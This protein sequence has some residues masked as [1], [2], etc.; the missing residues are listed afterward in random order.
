MTPMNVNLLHPDHDIDSRPG[1]VADLTADLELQ[2]LYSAM[3][4]GDDYLFEVAQRLV[5]VP[6]NDPE[7]ISYRQHVLADCLDDPATVQRMYTV[8][9]D[10]VNARRKVWLSGMMFQAPE[11]ILHRGVGLMTV[12]SANLR[13]IRDIADD[14]RTTFGSDGF[15]RLFAM[16]GEQLP[17]D[18]LAQIEH[19]VHELELHRGIAL[20]ARLGPGNKA[21]D[22]T[23]HRAPA[24]PNILH[25][26]TG[27]GHTGVDFDLPDRD[28][29]GAQALT[30][31][32]GHGIAD[33]AEVLS[34]A[35]DDIQAFFGRLRFELAFYLGCVNL[36][37]KLTELGVP[38]CF[39]NPS[40]PDQQELWCRGLRDVGLC[41]T[42]VAAVTGNDIDADG[43]SL[44]MITGANEGGKSTFLR[45]V[46]TAQTMMQAGMIVA[47]QNF[48]ADVRDQL[49]THFKREE[50]R[51]LTRGKLDEELARMRSIA[52]RIRPGS[53]LLCNESFASTNEREGSHIAADIVRAFTE[54]GVK[55]VYVT[56]LYDLARNLHDRDEATDLFLRAERRGDGT[57]TH[58]VLP[59]APEP[60]S[61]G[62]DSLARIFGPGN[63]DPPANG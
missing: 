1:N 63:G 47:A 62:Q 13:A 24:R 52:D 7:L 45:S 3:A 49:F 31:F 32:A 38:V 19:H 6:L 53:L 10:A 2:V 27:T 50:D 12:L 57:R 37:T 26:L 11:A 8:A 18:Y 39:P 44:I 42:T 17:D 35:V 15:R 16:L 9:T 46:G 58:R 48:R 20:S 33:A 55:I 5:P 54:M 34:Q 29:A 61:Y 56:H 21:C 43:A 30:A 40:P 60:T 59:G 25:R 22:F 23:L 51:T 36:Y 14:H 41:L 4:A 28:V